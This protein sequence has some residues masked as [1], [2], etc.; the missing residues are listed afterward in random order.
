[1]GEQLWSWVLVAI[2]VTGWILTGRRNRWGWAVSVLVQILW[3]VYAVVTSQ[4]GFILGAVLYGT[5]AGMNFVKWSRP[6]PE[7]VREA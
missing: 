1:M 4:Y 3:A 5:V 6:A 7:T 2:G